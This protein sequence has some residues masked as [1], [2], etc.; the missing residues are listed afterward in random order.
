MN[1]ED[2]KRKGLELIWDSQSDGDAYFDGSKYYAAREINGTR[3]RIYD[4]DGDVF[5]RLPS[6]IS[7]VD[8]IGDVLKIYLQAYE[9]GVNNGKSIRSREIKDLL[10]LD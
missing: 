10:E 3:V 7:S 5:L 9:K 1:I 4:E 6:S 8:V 2:L